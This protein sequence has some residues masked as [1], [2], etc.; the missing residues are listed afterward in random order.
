M[1]KKRR[2]NKRRRFLKTVLPVLL[3]VVAL[4]AV[5]VWKVF[6]VKDVEVVGNSIYTDDQIRD[7]ALSDEYSWNSLY[8]VLKNKLQKQE[9]IPFVDTM[10]ITL[11]SPSKIEIAVT[12]KGI[13]GYVYVSA[14]EMYAYFD[15]EGFVVELSEEIIDDTMKITGLAVEEATL[16][17]KLD[18]ENTSILKTLL[19]TT[20]LLLKYD[21]VPETIYVNGSSILLDYGKIQVNLGTGDD[22]S[23]KVL[24]MDTILST[25][26]EPCGTLHLETWSESGSDAYFKK[27]ELTQIPSDT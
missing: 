8:V 5:M 17:E 2:K 4:G 6:V 16:Y 3:L 7:W 27:D 19:A 10:S 18:L 26:D 20:Q 9:D 23:E 24:R 11:L 21:R 22:L 1:R 12:E 13:L 25:L 14:Q 15:Q